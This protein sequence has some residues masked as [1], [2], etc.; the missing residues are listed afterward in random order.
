M[1]IPEWK[2]DII[3]KFERRIKRTKRIPIFIHIPKCA[4]SYATQYIDYLRIFNNGHE[5]SSFYDKLTFSIIRNP[6]DRFESLLNY[7]LSELHPRKDWPSHLNNLHY[8]KSKTLNDVL[9]NMTDKEI[10]SF[11]PYKT[12][13]YWTRNVQL[14]LTIDEFIPALKLMGYNIDKEFPS[15]NISNKTRG[16]LNEDNR[17]RL[18]N[19]YKIDMAIYNYWTR[20]E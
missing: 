3:K 14:L 1:N 4:G 15:I 12:L 6:V 7:R 10:L 11:T 19:L 20:K 13:K 8:D 5:Q 2:V 18:E 9:S 16:K 17:M